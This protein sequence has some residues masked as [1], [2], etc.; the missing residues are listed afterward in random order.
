[1]KSVILRRSLVY[2]YY[3]LG[4]AFTAPVWRWGWAWL[5]KYYSKYLLKSVDLDTECR[6]W[7]KEKLDSSQICKPSS[8]TDSS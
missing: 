6:I 3:Y 7:K 4:N 1:M 5:Y 2:F 8:D